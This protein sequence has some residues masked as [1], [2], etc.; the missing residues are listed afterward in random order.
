MGFQPVYGRSVLEMHKRH[1]VTDKGRETGKMT[2]TRTKLEIGRGAGAA[3]E[4]ET[5][6]GLVKCMESFMEKCCC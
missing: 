6:T 4:M 5:R 3:I 1:I 2:R